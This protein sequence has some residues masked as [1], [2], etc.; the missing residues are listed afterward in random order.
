ME[1]LNEKREILK[2]ILKRDDALPDEYKE[3][4][5][6]EWLC[7]AGFLQDLLEGGFLE[8]NFKI[9]WEVEDGAKSVADAISPLLDDEMRELLK[10]ENR[11]LDGSPRWLRCDDEEHN[12]WCGKLY[13]QL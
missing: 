3:D 8:D 9:D 12:D 6:A 11:P 1:N 5:G 2:Q 13:D 10:E 7:C 4:Y